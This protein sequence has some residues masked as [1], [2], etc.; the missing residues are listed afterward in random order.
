[1][2][3]ERNERVFFFEREPEK[4]PLQ[5]S[6]FSFSYPRRSFFF[7]PFVLE[8]PSAVRPRVAEARTYSLH[9]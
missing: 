9:A 7:L 2:R 8:L 6:L 4:F 5:S 1:M 3:F